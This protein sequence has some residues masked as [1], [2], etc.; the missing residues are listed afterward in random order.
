VQAFCA[1]R[2]LLAITF[3][4]LS[5]TAATLLALGVAA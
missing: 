3:L 4:F 1:M 5:V 2:L